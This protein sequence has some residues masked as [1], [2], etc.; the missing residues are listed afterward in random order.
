MTTVLPAFADALP[1]RLG[2][3]SD[4]D[5]DPNELL[6]RARA[7]PRPVRSE[8]DA[9]FVAALEP[10]GAEALRRLEIAF[11]VTS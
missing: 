5:P 2:T 9:E 10:A 8:F 11:G 7:L 3:P 6:R 1:V 4:S